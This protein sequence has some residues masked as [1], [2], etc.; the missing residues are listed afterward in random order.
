M[1]PIGIIA[2]L[3]DEIAG[4]VQEMGPGAVTRH[5]G[6]RD[7]HVGTLYG[8]RCVIVL[9][10]VGKVAAAATTVTLIHEF[11]VQEVIF[12]GVAGAVASHVQ[13]GDVVVAHTL[14]QHDLDA[15]PLFAQYEVPLLERSCF[16]ADAVLSQRLYH[17][18]CSYL[19]HDAMLHIDTRT[20]DQFGLHAPAVHRGTIISGD[21]FVGNGQRIQALRQALPDALCVEMEGAAVAQICYEYNVPFAVLRTISDKADDSA[22]VDFTAFL[23]NVA[24]H[25]SAGVLRQFLSGPVVSAQA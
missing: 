21:Q 1:K 6:Q 4:L 2:A 5:I 15:R 17:S 18:I 8:Q 24:R 22:S 10:R 13:V 16:D 14:L 23:S 12:T 7:Y 20:R 11:D 19:Q 3:E 25:Y 9:A